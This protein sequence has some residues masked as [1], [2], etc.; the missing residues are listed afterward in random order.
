MGR[1]KLKQSILFAMVGP[2]IV[3]LV[4][5]LAFYL[6]NHAEYSAT[7]TD[8]LPLLLAIAAVLTGFFCALLIAVQSW[9]TIH[10]V[11]LGILVGIACPARRKRL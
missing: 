8:T 5:P 3:F 10:G 4:S 6:G 2:F 7:L 11:F 1:S 9:P